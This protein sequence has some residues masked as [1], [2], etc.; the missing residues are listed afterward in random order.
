MTADA[1]LKADSQSLSAY[2]QILIIEALVTESFQPVKQPIR[3]QKITWTKKA[4]LRL[5]LRASR[6]YGTHARNPAKWVPDTAR[7]CEQ[8]DSLKS[9]LTSSVISDLSPEQSAAVKALYFS[10]KD[11]ETPSITDFLTSKNNA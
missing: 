8:Q 10:E 4:F 3:T 5:I 9:R 1:R 6:T 7:R 2:T 11:A